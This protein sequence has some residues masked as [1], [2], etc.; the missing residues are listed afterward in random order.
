MSKLLAFTLAAGVS[1]VGVANAH[2][3]PVEQ[4]E[5]MQ[6]GLTTP[7]AT[8]CSVR[9][10]SGCGRD[11]A[12]RRVHSVVHV[13]RSYNRDFPYYPSQ[14]N[15][16]GYDAGQNRFCALGSYVACAYAGTYCWRRCY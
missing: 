3:T 8:G 16:S 11:L 4:F 7:A 14:F 13:N 9:G 10:D 12:A 2:A 15:V 5:S 1:I 6:P